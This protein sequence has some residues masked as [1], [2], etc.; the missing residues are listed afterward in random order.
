MKHPRILF[1]YHDLTVEVASSPG[2]EV[3]EHMYDT[4]LGTPGGLQA[5]PVTWRIMDFGSSWRN[6][7]MKLLAMIPFTRN[8]VD[9]DSLRLLAFEG[10]YCEPGHVRQYYMDHP[11][12][13]STYDNL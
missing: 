6:L 10:I 13:I 5:H 12:Y 8:R 1:T 11:T 2:E 4:V 7:V 3:M 9:P